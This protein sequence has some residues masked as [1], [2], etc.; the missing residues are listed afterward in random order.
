MLDNYQFP[1]IE[2]TNHL[3]RHRHTLDFSK[4][5][6]NCHELGVPEQ[7][8]NHVMRRANSLCNNSIYSPNDELSPSSLSSFSSST[9]SSNSS[10]SYYTPPCRTMKSKNST[11]LTLDTNQL[12]EN[13]CIRLQQ[14]LWNEDTTL[15]PKNEIAEYLGS[16]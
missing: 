7:P 14:R 6:I 16:K 13:G 4:M 2:N 11:K 8:M 15:C 9:I 1:I 3:R 5:I 10:S 12:N